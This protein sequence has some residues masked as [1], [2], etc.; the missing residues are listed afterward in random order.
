MYRFAAALP[1][2][3]RFAFRAV[4]DRRRFALPARFVVALLR[5]RRV[6]FD[7]APTRDPSAR[8]EAGVI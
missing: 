3:R 5:R 4:V 6:P 1:L 8:C 7:V 2:T